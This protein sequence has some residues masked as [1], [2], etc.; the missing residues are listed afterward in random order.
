MFRLARPR[1]YE[2]DL[3]MHLRGAFHPVHQPLS[4]D[5]EQIIRPRQLLLPGGATARGNSEPPGPE[6]IDNLPRLLQHPR[7]SGQGPEL[8]HR[9]AD[10]RVPRQQLPLLQERRGDVHVARGRLAHKVTESSRARGADFRAGIP[11]QSLPGAREAE[12]EA[13]VTRRE[14]FLNLNT[15]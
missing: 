12:T 8:I 6:N 5:R 2:R 14:M 10:A 7:D 4:P 3:E 9:P 1:K 13:Q 15:C 11:S